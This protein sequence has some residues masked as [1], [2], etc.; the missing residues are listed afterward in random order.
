MFYFR[1]KN[2][3][4]NATQVAAETGLSIS[5]VNR[6]Y[7]SLKSKDYIARESLTRGK[8]IILK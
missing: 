5:T 6:I 8:W 2:N 3:S 4:L 1:C 7:K